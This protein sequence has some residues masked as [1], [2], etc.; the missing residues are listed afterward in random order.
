MAIQLAKD[1]CRSHGEIANNVYY[2]IETPED[3][4]D[5]Y[6]FDFKLID[7][8]GQ[9]S[10]E[11]LAGAPGFTISK[12]VGGVEIIGWQQYQELKNKAD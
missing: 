4:G 2:D 8:E 7:K 10:Y 3:L 1:F 9:R 12:D 6:Y 11:M 5:Y